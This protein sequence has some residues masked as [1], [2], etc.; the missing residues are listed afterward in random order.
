M[1]TNQ[2]L[3]GDT[4]LGLISPYQTKKFITC[5]IVSFISRWHYVAQPVPEAPLSYLGGIK[6]G[7]SP[8]ANNSGGSIINDVSSTGSVNIFSA[9][10]NKG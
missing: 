8:W 6:Q 1:N 3:E 9:L 10:I 5:T 2:P 4:G 7:M